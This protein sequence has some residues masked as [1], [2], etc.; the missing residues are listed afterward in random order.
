MKGKRLKPNPNYK[1]DPDLREEWEKEEKEFINYLRE[2]MG[3]TPN[4]NNFRR[5]AQKQAAIFVQFY[6]LTNRRICG[7][8]KGCIHETARG[9]TS[10]AV[11]EICA[12]CTNFISIF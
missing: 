12:H 7:I 11:R 9:G 2:L 1:S 6:P 3:I 10:R 4:K 8:I 5:F